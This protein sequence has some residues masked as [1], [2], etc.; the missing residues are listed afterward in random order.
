MKKY[1][2]KKKDIEVP[3]IV[4]VAAFFTGAGL[5]GGTVQGG[6]LVFDGVTKYFVD[7]PKISGQTFAELMSKG[8]KFIHY[9]SI[10]KDKQSHPYI[11]STV[12]YNVQVGGEDRNY[13][14]YTSTHA[15]KIE[16]QE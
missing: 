2:S 15:L 7:K 6:L 1:F 8:G 9:Y 5:I 13:K 3:Y 11:H 4:N 10:T 16:S 14:I 12:F